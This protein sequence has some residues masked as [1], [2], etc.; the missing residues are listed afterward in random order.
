[1]WR[2]KHC[3]KKNEPNVF[4]GNKR[5]VEHKPADEK[6]AI[7][8]DI[9]AAWLCRITFQPEY[10]SLFY[11]FSLF[12]FSPVANQF[13][14][15]DEISLIEFKWWFLFLLSFNFLVG[16]T[17]PRSNHHIHSEIYQKSFP[18]TQNGPKPSKISKKCPPN[19]QL[20]ESDS[21]LYPLK[22]QRYLH[23]EGF[24]SK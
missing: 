3:A 15:N 21:N 13:S 2:K 19:Q 4:N 8:I 20:F 14:W 1:M 5:W 7:V 23:F 6:P 9:L 11:R 24:F 22:N 16:P 18:N 17:C 12:L 10:P